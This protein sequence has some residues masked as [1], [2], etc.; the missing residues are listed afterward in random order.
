VVEGIHKANLPL[1]QF[2]VDMPPFDP[3]HPD[4]Y[5]QFDVPAEPAHMAPK[6]YG[7]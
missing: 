2:L 3:A 4:P 1:A 5:A 6:P 7:Q